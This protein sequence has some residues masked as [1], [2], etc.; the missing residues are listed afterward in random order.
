MSTSTWGGSEPVSD[1]IYPPAFLKHLLRQMMLQFHAEGA[2]IALYDEHLSQMRVQSHVRLQPSSCNAPTT[3]LPRV[4]PG[5][6]RPTSGLP[7][8]LRTPTSSLPAI[9]PTSSTGPLAHADDTFE[10]SDVSPEQCELF[11]VGTTYP[12]GRDLIGLVWQK[13]RLYTLTHEDYLSL[14]HTNQKQLPFPVGDPPTNYLVTP[15]R[16]AT[17]LNDLTSE[18]QSSSDP[19]QAAEI[20][21]VIVLYQLTPGIP[22][23]QLQRSDVLNYAERVALYLQNA[24]LQHNQ[25]RTSEYLQQLQQISTAF[26]N[27]VKLADLVESIHHFTT[28]LVDAPSMMLTLYDRDLDR[29]Y[30]VFAIRN[31]EQITGLADQPLV[32]LKEERPVWWRVTQQDRHTLAFSPTQDSQKAQEYQEL[33]V[34]AW[35]DQR[36]AKSF[37]LI[38]M[39]MFTRVTGSLSIASSQPNAYHP[40]EIQV[41][42]TMAQIVTVSIENAKLYERDRRILQESTQREAHLAALNNTLQS[43]SSVLNITEL[44]NNLVDSVAAMLNVDMCVFFQPSTNNE[45]LVA[46]ALHAPSNVRMIDDGSGMPGED[47]PPN[48]G[49]PDELITLIQIPLKGSFLAPAIHGGFFYLDPSQLEE[50][51]RLS[52]EAGQEAG[53]IFLRE[54][55]IQ[56]LLLVPLSYQKA[57]LGFLGVS[58]PGGSRNFRPKDVGTLLAICAQAAGA[59]RNAQLFAQREEAYA[60]MERMSKLKDEFLVTA[61]H[62]LRTPLTAIHGYAGQLRRQANR[63]TP[64]QI[65]RSATRVTLAAQQLT[66][67]LDNMYEAANVAVLDRK[68]ELHIESVQLRSACEIAVNMLTMHSE[69]EVAQDLPANLWLRGDGPRVRQVLTNL[70]ENAAKYSPPNTPITVTAQK[71]QLSEVEPL[72]SGDQADPTLLLDQGDIPVVLVKVIDQ[73]EGIM[74]EDQLRIF[75]KFVR[76]PRSLTTPV[77]GTGLGLYICRRFVEAMGGKIWLETSIPNV[78]STFCF[79][80]PW[81]EAP[82]D[83]EED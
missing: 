29:L 49:V 28:H 7:T 37:L 11:T 57:F 66:Y 32:R 78:G 1:E 80:L 21:G 55:N 2:C 50:L 60:E 64:Q 6:R 47:A 44:L 22:D 76:A 61:S 23:F 33:L 31:G 14:L 59:I 75:E 30:D 38:P 24:H 71:M 63:A 53:A 13:N 17:L 41:L 34:G 70:L 72:L 81:V 68:Q 51:A 46:Q 8:D 45:T 10:V 39:K 18:G 62:E 25:R 83:I 77:R 3:T 35:G 54:T 74:A 20:L 36:G 73:G 82:V 43:I 58:T 16:A 19:A 56:N 40:E 42:E 79:Y 65:L 69:H 27:S 48:R 15:I 67:L 12:R 4:G 52:M 26:P 9:A 5:Q